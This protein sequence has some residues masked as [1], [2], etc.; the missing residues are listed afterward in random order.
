MERCKMAQGIQLV[1]P[2]ARVVALSWIS[3]SSPHLILHIGWQMPE[4]TAHLLVNKNYII[5]FG[6]E[7]WQLLV[8]CVLHLSYIKSL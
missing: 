8:A 1:A 7:H 3:Y 4:V 2:L 6:F 5:C